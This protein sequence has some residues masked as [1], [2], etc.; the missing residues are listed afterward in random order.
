M[1]EVG[2]IREEFALKGVVPLVEVSVLLFLL[3]VD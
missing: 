1:Q 2:V 3:A